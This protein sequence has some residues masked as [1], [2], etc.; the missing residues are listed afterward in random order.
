[1][2]GQGPDSWIGMRVRVYLFNAGVPDVSTH[3]RGVN[4]LGITVDSIPGGRLSFYPWSAVRQID[5]APSD[6]TG[7]RE[8]RQQQPVAPASLTPTF[9]QTRM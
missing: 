7:Q 3:L 6:D 2:V 9:P 1:M 5:Y 4:E 8:P